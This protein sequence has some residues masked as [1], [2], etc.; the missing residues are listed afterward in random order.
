MHVCLLDVNS[1]IYLYVMCVLN[2]TGLPVR[3]CGMKQILVYHLGIVRN[4]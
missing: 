3:K 1:K 2:I 4:G